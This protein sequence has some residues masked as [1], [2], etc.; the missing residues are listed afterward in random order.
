MDT[1]L[2]PEAMVL[3]FAPPS[4]SNPNEEAVQRYLEAKERAKII[5]RTARNLKQAASTSR[6]VNKEYQA[7]KLAYKQAYEEAGK[8][9]QEA[10]V[11]PRQ[12]K[13]NRTKANRDDAMTGVKMSTTSGIKK[14]TKARMPKVNRKSSQKIVTG[15]GVYGWSVND[16]E[17]ELDR[18]EIRELQAKKSMRLLLPP[19]QMEAESAAIFSKGRAERKDVKRNLALEAAAE[20]LVG[21][22][23]AAGGKKR[24]NGAGGRR[25]RKNTLT[26]ELEGLE[27]DQRAFMGKK[28]TIADF[29]NEEACKERVGAVGALEERT[30]EEKAEI[31]AISE[32]LGL[33]N[34]GRK[35][36]T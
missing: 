6:E 12:R 18:E 31:D 9:K 10:G 35:R 11:P 19:P 34:M 30:V 26:E 13:R 15:T 2:Q 33:V 16:G 27:A 4:T 8:L 20:E 17:K 32:Q 23:D 25:T 36:E 21:K 22:V 24:M 14:K 5:G 28:V 29:R 1:N 3:D 7:A